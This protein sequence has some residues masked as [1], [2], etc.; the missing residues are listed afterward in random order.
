M[1]WNYRV[2]LTEVPSFKEDGNPVL[3]AQ[4]YEVYYNE[5][6]V[7]SMRTV[8]P[9]SAYG[10]G[11]TV[12]EAV[13]ELVTS[14]RRMLAYAERFAAVH[15]LDLDKEIDGEENSNGGEETLN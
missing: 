4:I 14:L 10:E 9:V 11:E 15:I 2:L 6:G 12:A 1:T 8:N 7:P 3:A 13:D 5:T